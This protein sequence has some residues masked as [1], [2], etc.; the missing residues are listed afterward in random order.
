MQ[1]NIQSLFC[2]FS[3]LRIGYQEWGKGLEASVQKRLTGTGLLDA[4]AKARCTRITKGGFSPLLSCCSDQERLET[5]I[6]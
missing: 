6:P 4:R 3:Q 5:S 2:F 1:C